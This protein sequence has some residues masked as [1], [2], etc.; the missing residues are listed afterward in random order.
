[1]REAKGGR[2][3]YSTRKGVKI[4]ESRQSDKDATVQVRLSVEWRDMLAHM[5]IDEGRSIRG[6]IED[7]LAETYSD[8]QSKKE[9]HK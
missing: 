1:M 6:L 7:A 5:R 2:G 3:I 8:Y 9:T 4:M